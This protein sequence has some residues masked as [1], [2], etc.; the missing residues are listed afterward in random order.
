[1]RDVLDLSL[2]LHEI[3]VENVVYIFGLHGRCLAVSHA[4]KC[5]VW[6]LSFHGSIFA[7]FDISL[8]VSILRPWWVEMGMVFVCL[9]TR[10]TWRRG[11]LAVSFFYM[12]CEC[13][14]SLFEFR[15]MH[16][17][18][19]ILVFAWWVVFVYLGLS[20]LQACAMKS[21]V[22][23]HELAWSLSV[24]KCGLSLPLHESY[25]EERLASREFLHGMWMCRELV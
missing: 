5:L 3:E 11:W 10:V 7:W 9:S 17:R 22:S 19:V 23:L 13:A 4:W 21:L 2:I 14:V 1:M 24:Y 18:S 6:S 16:V 8:G 15:S 25:M 12:E 20:L